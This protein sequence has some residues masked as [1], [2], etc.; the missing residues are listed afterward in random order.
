[1]PCCGMSLYFFSHN[2][3][4]SEIRITFWQRF[5]GLKMCYIQFVFRLV[6]NWCKEYCFLCYVI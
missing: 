5:V 3:N 1:M 2:E 4:F 6:F